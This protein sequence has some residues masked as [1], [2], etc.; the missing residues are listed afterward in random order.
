M[1]VLRDRVRY[2]AV[3]GGTRFHLLN[4]S[5]FVTCS[6]A[7]SFARQGLQVL[8]VDLGLNQ[9][10]IHNVLRLENTYGLMSVLSGL[11]RTRDAIQRMQMNSRLCVMP[12]GITV[13][14]PR[15]AELLNGDRMFR[16]LENLGVSPYIHVFLHEPPST[17]HLTHAATP[18]PRYGGIGRR[19][20]SRLVDA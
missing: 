20:A 8:V 9:P 14:E 15:A 13:S 6:L 17:Q 18:R 10:T 2:A 12:A 19:R 7:E 4:G 16:F 1:S 11:V 3:L 5:P